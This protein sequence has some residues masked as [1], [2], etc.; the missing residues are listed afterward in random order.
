[1][2]WLFHDEVLKDFMRV[3]YLRLWRSLDLEIRSRQ[4][5]A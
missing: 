4:F 1:M 5:T 2:C 3:A